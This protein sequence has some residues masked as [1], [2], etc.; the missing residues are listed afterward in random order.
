LNDESDQLK[1]SIEG[2]VEVK[3]SDKPEHKEYAMLGF[4]AGDIKVLVSKPS[5]CGFGMNFQSCNR[6]A[7]VGVSHSYE[8]TYQ[9]IR[10][11]WR[12]GQKEEVHV[13]FVYGQMERAIVANL[14]RKQN[15]HQAMSDAMIG[16]MSSVSDL[17]P[18]K[19]ITNDYEAGETMILPK[20]LR[21]E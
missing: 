8:Q 7:F 4:A 6:M 1:R 11:C 9:A 12:F 20:W 2:S 16:A 10:R 14:T 15:S 18:T 19:A 5:I 13:H 3:G 21:G 17:A